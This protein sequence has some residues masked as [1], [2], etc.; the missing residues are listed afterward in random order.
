MTPV[1]TVGLIGW[2]AELAAMSDV[3]I[4][5]LAEA[6]PALGNQLRRT[7]HTDQY[8]ACLPEDGRRR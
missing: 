5:R 7:V 8:T 4:D 1:T 6:H 3:P 2:D